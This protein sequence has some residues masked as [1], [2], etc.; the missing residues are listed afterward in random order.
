MP[1]RAV[2][3]LPSNPVPGSSTS[4]ALLRCAFFS[5][6][7]RD[8]S[9]PTSSSELICMHHLVRHGHIQIAQSAHGENEERD[10]GFHIEHARSPEPAVFLPEWHGGQRAQRPYRIGMAQRQNLSLFLFPE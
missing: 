4:T 2:L 5:V 8:D 3:S 10:A 7:A 6:S 9:L 1:L